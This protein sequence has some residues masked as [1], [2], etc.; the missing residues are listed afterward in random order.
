MLPYPSSSPRKEWLRPVAVLVPLALACG[1]AFG[2]SFSTRV[3]DFNPLGLG[4]FV[5]TGKDVDLDLG[6]TGKFK[7]V[8]TRE[9]SAQATYDSNFFLTENDEE[10]EIRMSISPVFRYLSDPEGGA[11][12]SI[13]A[14][15]APN[16]SAFAENSDL[17][18]FN[19]VGDLTFSFNG[20]RTH[21]DVFGS[22]SQVSSTDEVTGEF[23]DAALMTGG[24]RLTRQIA[25]RTTL[26]AGWA[27]SMSDYS[28]GGDEGA[29]MYS[30]YLGGIWQA[31]E[32]LGFGSTL[33]YTITTSDNID[34][35]DSWALLLEAR[36]QASERIWLS[37]SL[38]PEYSSNDESGSS[39]GLT[40]DVTARY[41]INERWTWTG[42]LV[43]VTVPSP[44]ETGYVIN[45]T[46][47]T[48]SL[49]RELTR[50]SIEGGLEYRFSEYEEVGPVTSDVG[51]DE[52][53]AAFVGYGRELFS[54]RVA[55]NSRLRYAINDG[56]RDWSQFEFS[57][58]VNVVF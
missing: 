20:A 55:F 42:S 37:A 50:G 53:L 15:Y 10:D 36:Y 22:Y 24:L 56:E 4:A 13:N 11:K 25:T 16:Y 35:L 12:Y 46:S 44:D 1:P 40:G 6:L 45:N 19:Q 8:F 9:L 39:I 38:G 43:S 32:R 49:Q 31:T 29:E 28:S 34:S 41:L 17:N 21:L 3:G 51:N 30:S 47:V 5:P 18:S 52:N 57:M 7:G 58:G 33:R 48:T 27:A 14:G 2:Q 23:V 26:N 54:E